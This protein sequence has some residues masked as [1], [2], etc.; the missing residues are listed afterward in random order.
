V[1]RMKGLEVTDHD[2]PARLGRLQLGG[3]PISTPAGCCLLGAED[4][5]R[6][7]SI[8][9][10][11]DLTLAVGPQEGV[12]GIE[13]ALLRERYPEATILFAHPPPR[14]VTGLGEVR[15][16]YARGGPEAENMLVV[17]EA[18]ESASPSRLLE[19][20][21]GVREEVSSNVALLVADVPVWAMPLMALA[22]ADLLGDAHAYGSSVS[23]EMIFGS[24]AI[25]FDENVGCECPFCADPAVGAGSRDLLSHN[26][27]VMGMALSE[28]R[29]RMR[30]GKLKH[31]AEE[32]AIG[33]PEVYAALKSL[34]SDHYRYLERHTTICPGLRP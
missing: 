8:G 27:W 21:I 24:Y 2:G 16:F 34:Y 31:M 20:V 1:S 26:R 5:F 32:R 19:A 9:R 11:E 3:K 18:G 22:G 30:L 17:V 15:I 7:Y 28:I 12:N 23:N 6:L 33:H 10:R 25:P 29:N 14:S 13:H 4:G